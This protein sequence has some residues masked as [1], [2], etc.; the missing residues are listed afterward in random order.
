MQ[1]VIALLFRVLHLLGRNTSTTML[2]IIILTLYSAFITALH[3]PIRYYGCVCGT[4]WIGGCDT[5]VSGDVRGQNVCRNGVSSPFLEVWKGSVR[6]NS[7]D[8]A[9]PRLCGFPSVRG[10]LPA[11]CRRVCDVTRLHLYAYLWTRLQGCSTCGAGTRSRLIPFG[12]HN[13]PRYT[14]HVLIACV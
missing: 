8:V 4:K 1:R 10:G 2:F 5:A 7:A 3:L 9:V 14:L 12:P 11:P 13:L 6:K